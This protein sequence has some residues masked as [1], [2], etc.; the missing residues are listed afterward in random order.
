MRK[1]LTHSVYITHELKPFKNIILCRE[2]FIDNESGLPAKIIFLFTQNQTS[3]WQMRNPSNHNVYGL[4]RDHKKF[5][6]LSLKKLNLI[7]YLLSKVQTKWKKTFRKYYFHKINSKTFTS[8][9]NEY[10]T[11]S[12]LCLIMVKI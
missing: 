12:G 3:G 11:T 5:A 7:L 2:T 4:R 10:M 1:N 8:R 9:V 6:F